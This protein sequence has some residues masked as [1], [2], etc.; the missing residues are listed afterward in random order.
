MDLLTAFNISISIAGALGG[1]ALKSI[2]D[3]QRD[4]EK[5]LDNLPNLY[6]R[7][8]DFK[9]TGE[10]IFRKLDRIEEKLDRKVDK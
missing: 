1:W 7:R 10:A 5:R 4:I 9:E 6:T 8:D 3:A 2:Y